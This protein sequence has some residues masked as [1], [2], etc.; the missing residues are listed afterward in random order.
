M[1]KAFSASNPAPVRPASFPSQSDLKDGIL[2]GTY[3]MA[4]KD[5]TRDQWYYLSSTF[6]EYLIDDPPYWDFSWNPI[7][8]GSPYK[9]TDKAIVVATGVPYLGDESRN[10]G[11]SSYVSG[12]ILNL[13]WWIKTT[14]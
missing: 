6:N 11:P 4:F 3:T 2:D 7:T 8:V 9:F 5:Q 1:L 14:W 10:F 12:D 13:G